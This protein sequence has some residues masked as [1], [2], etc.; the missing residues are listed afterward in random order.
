M[1]PLPLESRLAD[2]HWRPAID[3]PTWRLQGHGYNADE[4]LEVESL[5]GSALCYRRSAATEVGG[6]A[7]A[8]QS[9]QIYREDSDMSARLLAAGYVL[10]VSTAARGGT[11]SRHQAAVAST[12]RRPPAT[13]W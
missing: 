11:W 7:V 5:W 13:S 8:G 4:I 6:W 9:E 2:P 10:V 3:R 12:V 1:R